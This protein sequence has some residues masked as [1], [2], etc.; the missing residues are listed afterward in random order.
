MENAAK[1]LEMS[2]LY[3]TLV[4]PHDT[5]DNYG[6]ALD[7]AAR[8]AEHMDGASVVYENDAGDEWHVRAEG[9]AIESGWTPIIEVRRVRK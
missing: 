6:D 3:W 9:V 2:R 1:D 8:N 5:H 7:E 4:D